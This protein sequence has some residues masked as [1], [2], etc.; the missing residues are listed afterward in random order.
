PAGLVNNDGAR[1]SRRGP[2]SHASS[3]LPPAARRSG[4]GRG[5]G[6]RAAAKRIHPRRPRRRAGPPRARLVRPVEAAR[7]LSTRAPRRSRPAPAPRIP[8]RIVPAVRPL[9]LTPRQVQ[10][11]FEALLAAGTVL[12]VA[13]RARTRPRRLLALHPPRYELALFDTRF[14]L[15]AVRQ[16]PYVRF[17]VAYVVQERPGRAGSDAW[18]RLFYK[19][20]SLIWRSAS[21]VG[22]QQ[23]AFWL[24]KG[25]VR[26]V[27]QGG[28]EYVWSMESTTDLPVELQPAIEALS[29][30]SRRIPRDDTAPELVLRRAPDG[31]IEPYHD[32]VAPRRR[33]QSNPRN[34][35]NGGR[36]VAW[37]TR[38][39][40]PGSLRFA[41]GYEPDL[42]AGLIG[43]DV[44]TSRLYGGEIRRFRILS[45]NRR[46]QYLFMAAPRHV[47][48]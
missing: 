19:D 4:P 42:R 9:A 29:R 39:G 20:G 28:E 46:I 14:F 24:G 34:L 26:T 15:A 7:L 25:D 37:F 30:R 41:A 10:R 38:P 13:G 45:H 35:V 17:F 32:F 27:V 3:R 8:T 6:R 43:E 21:H 16:N 48:I 2:V 31:R 44:F 47:W 12:R 36:P 22:R 5:G 11:R 33:A 40:D 18:A 1:R 23:G